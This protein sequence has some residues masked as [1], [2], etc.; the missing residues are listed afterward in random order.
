[1][2]NEPALVTKEEVGSKEQGRMAKG[3]ALVPVQTR[4]LLSE[5]L[6]YPP[7]QLLFHFLV[8]F[9]FFLYLILSLLFKHFLLQSASPS[10]GFLEACH[11]TVAFSI[12]FRTGCTLY[13]ASPKACQLSLSQGSHRM[14]KALG[15][16]MSSAVFSKHEYRIYLFQQKL[17]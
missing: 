4:W 14:T 7:L 2:L 13:E 11:I 6:F 3:E 12:W 1:M 8:V 16:T 10:N 5:P 15:K 9:F 17:Q